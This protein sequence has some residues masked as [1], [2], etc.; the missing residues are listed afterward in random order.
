MN[1]NTKNVEWIEVTCQ[2]CGC[3]IS[4]E[5]YHKINAN[6]ALQNQ[7]EILCEAH[8]IKT[9]AL[10]GIIRLQS[11]IRKYYVGRLLA[12]I[13]NRQRESS[14][15][16]DD[17]TNRLD[18]DLIGLIPYNEDKFH[19]Y[20][21]TKSSLRSCLVSIGLITLLIIQ[22]IMRFYRI[23][24]A[25]YSDY[26]NLVSII[27]IITGVG[28]CYMKFL[29]S[30]SD[31]Y[32]LIS[33]SKVP[34]EKSFEVFIMLIIQDFFIISVTL[35]GGFFLLQKAQYGPCGPSI[36][37]PWIQMFI[38][39]SQKEITEYIPSELAVIILLLPLLLIIILQ[40][41]KYNAQWISLGIAVSFILYTIYITN[42]MKSLWLLFVVVPVV[43]ISLS[44]IYK[45]N[46]LIFNMQEMLYLKSK[47]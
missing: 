45:Q 36:S 29:M 27:V 20:Q 40:T 33:E 18:L 46:V 11:K 9:Y 35:L 2:K 44:K 25:I 41:S 42:F 23:K 24:S 10:R 31:F 16:N 7:T 8:Y 38:C 1:K 15:H 6:I 22:F 19:F 39:T 14:T 30:T 28:V 32:Q 26:I 34:I 43:V 21:L 47:K 12:I 4:R 5:N 13:N 17:Q 37:P 3:L